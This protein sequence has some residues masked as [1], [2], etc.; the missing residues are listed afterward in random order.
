MYE[1]ERDCHLN[2]V[3]SD[4]GSQLLRKNRRQQQFSKTGEG[5]RV[6]LFITPSNPLITQHQ[7]TSFPLTHGIPLTQAASKGGLPGVWPQ[8]QESLTQE[9]LTHGAA[10]LFAHRSSVCKGGL[11]L[12]S[13]N[14]KIWVFFS[15]V[16]W[17]ESWGT[18]NRKEF[19]WVLSTELD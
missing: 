11:W 12:H 7:R 10:C 4:T 14:R 8:N 2:N 3:N 5:V 16:F 13:K 9:V 18:M 6:T 19:H 1:R 17:K 15:Q